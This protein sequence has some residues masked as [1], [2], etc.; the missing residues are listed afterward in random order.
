M[1]HVSILERIL[2][3][4]FHLEGPP[5]R[6]LAVDISARSGKN[7]IDPTA[8]RVSARKWMEKHRLIIIRKPVKGLPD[9]SL[10]NCHN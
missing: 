6:N 4:G 1:W 2:T 3:E 9:F 7:E 8:W 10:K 5:V